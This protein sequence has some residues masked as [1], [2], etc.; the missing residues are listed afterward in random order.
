MTLVDLFGQPAYEPAG[1]VWWTSVAIVWLSHLV[2]PLL[3]WVIWRLATRWRRH[4]WWW[5][6]SRPV[7]AA[8]LL[9]FVDGRFVEPQLITV[10]RTALG[11]GIPARVALVSDLHLGLFHGPVFLQRVVERLNELDV[12]AVLVAGDHTYLPDRP[13][14]ELMAPWSASRHPVYAVLGNHDEQRPGPPLAGALR[15]ALQRH[16]VRVIE[17]QAVDMGRWTLVGLGD[18][19]AGL[20]DIAP[21]LHAPADRPRVV[22]AHNPDSSMAFPKGAAALL[23]AGHTHGGQI[24]IPGLYRLHL[25]SA[26]YGGFDRGFY[27]VTRVPVYVTSGLGESHLPLRL[28]NPPVVDVLDLR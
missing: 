23:M 12:D 22:L 13:L 18:R 24:R 8:V 1:P 27:T 5:R 15:A 4:G 7:L 26:T 10:Q 2:W 9:L 6:L 21:V 14:D 3:A 20:D 16:H 11:L 19:Y 25:R 28:F 17:Q